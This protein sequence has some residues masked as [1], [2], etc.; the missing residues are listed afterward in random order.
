MSGYRDH[1]SGHAG[2]YAAA[3]PTYPQELFDWL[4]TLVEDREL[5]WDAA[6]GNGQAA[7]GLLPLFERVV[8]SD[9]S[10]N[11]VFQALVP[12]VEFGVEPAESP[13]FGPSEVDLITVAQAAHWLDHDR[14][15]ATVRR[16]LKPGGILAVWCYERC[17]VIPAIDK[18]LESYYQSLDSYWPPERKFV[19][20]G[21]RTL[22]FPFEDEI[23]APSFQIRC[24][25]SA[26]QMLAYLGS[27][28]ATR[29]CAAAENRDPI[30]GISE[31]LGAGWGKGDHEVVWPISMRVGRNSGPNSVPD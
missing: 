15:E 30:E 8:A 26:A 24:R 12:G 13:R 5:A 17:S 22:P 3:R 14:F 19:E 7:R 10:A 9:A 4:S 31:E 16:V 21:Y 29:R 20:E 25:W 18:I 23:V 28:S 11:Q 1:F 27:W 2:D 6:T